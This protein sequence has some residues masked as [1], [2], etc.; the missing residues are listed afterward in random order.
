[1]KIRRFIA[2]APVL[3][4]SALAGCQSEGSSESAEAAAEPA[5][6]SAANDQ[7]AMKTSHV[8]EVIARDFSFEAPARI[9]SGWTTFRFK[10]AGAQEHF[11]ALARMPEG[12]TVDDY[13][14][15]IAAGAF[16]GAMGPYYDGE[17]ELDAALEQ[18]G[19]LLPA[20][21]FEVVSAGGPGLVSGGGTAETTV[22]LDPGYYVIECYVKSPEGV[23]HVALGM[24]VGFVVTDEPSGAS[25]PEA[26]FDVTLANYV[27][28]APE[29]VPAGKHTVR[30]RYLQDPEGMLRHD[31]HLVRLGPDSDLSELV[32]WMSW[33]D[34]MVSP[35]PGTFIGGS[36]QM[37]A[38]DVSYMRVDLEPG[39]YAWISEA[40][41]AQGMVKEFVVE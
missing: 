34:G 18:L 32:P 10:N 19:A 25:A 29:S 28:E 33:I 4:F 21:F 22:E 14:D 26:D 39:T 16:G 13:R 23:F 20:W 9:P 5:A 6:K 36:E 2:L 12:K 8:V 38:G 37:H 17:V 27:I 15:D 3:A 35:A 7:G 30:V 40:Y 31:V 11:M 1:M 24:L 41:A